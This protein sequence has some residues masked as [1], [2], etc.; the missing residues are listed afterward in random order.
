MTTTQP[1]TAQRLRVRPEAGA[2]FTWLACDSLDAGDHAQALTLAR[3]AR[4]EAEQVE[5]AAIESSRQASLTWG[6][7]GEALGITKQAAQQRVR[8]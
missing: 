1:S 6:A 3:A 8:R 4:A 5:R 7:I 2:S